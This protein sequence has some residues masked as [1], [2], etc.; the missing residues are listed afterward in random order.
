[1]T[2]SWAL[3]NTDQ[4]VCIKQICTDFSDCSVGELF[5][6]L[7]NTVLGSLYSSYLDVDFS[8][9]PWK[10][11]CL[12]STHHRAEKHHHKCVSKICVN[13]LV[14]HLYYKSATL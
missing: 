5:G 10:N 12:Y 14:F 11:P 3:G 7:E 1:M 6:S 9:G 13:S 4:H 8:V 2:S